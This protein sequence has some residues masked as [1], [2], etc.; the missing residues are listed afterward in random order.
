LGVDPV[1][2]RQQWTQRLPLPELALPA[3]YAPAYESK[4]TVDQML[5]LGGVAISLAAKVHLNPAL[6]F[7]LRQCFPRDTLY[8]LLAAYQLL[9][10]GM[11]LEFWS[12]DELGSRLLI[13]EPKLFRSAGR[14][15][16]HALRVR[17]SEAT[18]LLLPQVPI[19]IPMQS[20]NY[21]PDFLGL[22]VGPRQFWFTVE[23]DGKFHQDKADEDARR[24]VGIG[25]REL[26][27]ANS[28]LLRRDWPKRLV[29]DIRRLA[30]NG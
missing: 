28:L 11:Q 7:E 2:I 25:L 22:Y 29:G 23:L 5:E 24:A 3:L 13:C 9:A 27:Y 14:M 20:R 26:R 21:R 19:A 12:T 17:L 1:H 15:L 30:E 10:G 4:A 6:E 18:L 8:E 16:R